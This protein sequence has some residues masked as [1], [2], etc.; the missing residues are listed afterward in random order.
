MDTVR[1]INLD[2]IGNANEIFIANDKE[3]DSKVDNDE[4]RD[5][6]VD[7]VDRKVKFNETGK[8]N[9]VV[10]ENYKEK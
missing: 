9:E 6:S 8:T 7:D 4:G 2:K 5:E 3:I 10:I 1:K